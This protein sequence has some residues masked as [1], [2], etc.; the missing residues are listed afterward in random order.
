MLKT[1]FDNNWW[2]VHP[3]KDKKKNESSAITDKNNGKL[4]VEKRFVCL[5]NRSR[6]LIWNSL[7]FERLKNG[8]RN[9]WK[10]AWFGSLVS[11]STHS[12]AP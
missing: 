3:N 12:S 6:T 4:Q 11:C 8:E 7:G 2:V 5:I 9:A 10:S 1:P